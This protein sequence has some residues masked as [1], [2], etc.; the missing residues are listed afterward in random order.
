MVKNFIRVLVCLSM[1]MAVGCGANTEIV[2]EEVSEENNVVVEEESPT[3]STTTEE[4][5]EVLDI[6]ESAETEIGKLTLIKAK[7]VDDTFTTGSFEMTIGTISIAEIMPKQSYRQIFDN[8]EKATL[9]SI[10]M[11][12][13]NTSPE[14]IMFHPNQGTIVV[15]QE[16]KDAN[17][18]MSDNIG[19]DFIGQVIKEGKVMFIMTT[20]PEDISSVKYVVTAPFSMSQGSIGDDLTLEFAVDQ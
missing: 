9:V 16:Q 2:G 1:I 5:S 3:T 13:E 15:G 11:K 4:N 20:P 14:T 18:F 6:G 19:G 12:V 17:I 8:R 10:G 7:K